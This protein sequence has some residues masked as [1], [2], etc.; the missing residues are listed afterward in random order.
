[1]HPSIERDR[2]LLD[3]KRVEW[4]ARR[5][6][7]ITKETK[8]RFDKEAAEQKLVAT[9]PPDN[10]ESA[11]S[12]EHYL[13]EVLLLYEVKEW[14]EI[15]WKK[16]KVYLDR[17]GN[18]SDRVEEKKRLT[19]EWRADCRR[20]LNPLMHAAVKRLSNNRRSEWLGKCWASSISQ[21]FEGI[22]K[23]DSISLSK[24][25][26]EIESY[27]GAEMRLR[28]EKEMED[29][30]F[31][32]KRGCDLGRFDQFWD[33]DWLF[34]C[35]YSGSKWVYLG[36][37]SRVPLEV[38]LHALK[39]RENIIHVTLYDFNSDSDGKRFQDTICDLPSWVTSISCDKDLFECLPAI[40]RHP[41]FINNDSDMI[42]FTKLE[43]NQF[44]S[45]SSTYIFTD[46]GGFDMDPDG[47]RN[48]ARVL[49][50]FV[51]PTFGR[52]KLRLKHSGREDGPL[53][54]NLGST[55][56]QLNPSSKSS[57][58]I[59][60]ITL[61]PIQDP[62]S[63]ETDRLSFEPGRNGIF[64]QFG[65]RKKRKSWIQRHGHI[66]HDIELL[67]EAGLEYPRNGRPGP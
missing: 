63:S 35:R 49:I 50:S 56:I 23:P 38:Y 5:M 12:W 47:L 53:E 62:G 46:A 40:H 65:G 19:R 37:F 14:E 18:D 20:R 22:E 52:L 39:G 26:E 67:D 60:D 29:T 61:Y 4:I 66:L 10:I 44:E 2:R 51:A 13:M 11:L 3:E 33:E 59:D 34:T 48:N 15:F 8:E 21:L 1:M 36:N 43:E 30:H 27:S 45:N 6:E 42:T 64:I 7:T 41:L 32:L 58:T 16:I 28:M 24:L 25:K 9:E 31:R 55:T 54:V 17:I 57:I